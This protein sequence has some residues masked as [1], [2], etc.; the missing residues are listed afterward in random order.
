MTDPRDHLVADAGD[1]KQATANPTFPQQAA[2]LA[3]PTPPPDDHFSPS[4]EPTKPG[5]AHKV[6]E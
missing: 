1:V 5:S 3:Q 2:A 4:D 6:F